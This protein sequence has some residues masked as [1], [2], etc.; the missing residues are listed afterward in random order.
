ME[1]NMRR[2]R[3]VFIAF[4][5]LGHFSFVQSTVHAVPG[6]DKSQIVTDATGVRIVER[7]RVTV[8]YTGMAIEYAEAIARIAES[9]Y[10]HYQGGYHFD[11]PDRLTIEVDIDRESTSG[12]WIADDHT[13]H[14]HY[15]SKRELAPPHRSRV[16]TIYGLTYRI[17]DL[18][19]ERTL[20]D[21]LWL[22]DDAKRGLSHLCA[23][24]MMD[25]LHALHGEK[26]WPQAYD[27][28]ESG[29][30]QLRQEIDRRNAPD[31]IQAAAQWHALE[32]E[33]GIAAVG[34][35]LGTWRRAS[36]SPN[37]P[38]DGLLNA[39][40]GRGVETRNRSK[41]RRWFRGF[42]PA[43]VWT[44]GRRA[45]FEQS[46]NSGRLAREPR[47]LKYDDDAGDGAKPISRGGHIITFQS[48]DDVWYVK[49]V[50]F[51]GERYGD[52]PRGG[53]DFVITILDEKFKSIASWRKPYGLLRGSSAGWH[54]IDVPVTRLPKKFVVSIEFDSSRRVGV[55]VSADGSSQGHSASGSLRTGIA[56]LDKADWMIRVEIDRLKD[57]NPLKYRPDAS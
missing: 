18:G 16:D 37:R 10:S 20:G 51:H 32:R 29:W 21:V 41:L 45:K 8:R 7:P 11:M 12:I 39:L 27:Y 25:R 52:L 17:A 13:I 31:I 23:C 5:A 33:F 49:Q 1:L 40:T 28:V 26:L 24:R 2:C 6:G 3:S 50:Q 53:K 48:P 9:T 47:V 56:P 38:A 44:A 42:E 46:Y 55:N 43:C 57:D 15:K 36:I 34:D 22:S 54:R 19:R 35:T 4:V 30:R 14:I